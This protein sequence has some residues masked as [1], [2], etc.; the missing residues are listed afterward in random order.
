M[1]STLQILAN[2]FVLFVGFIHPSYQ[3]TE[4]LLSRTSNWDNNGEPRL[5]SDYLKLLGDMG[6]FKVGMEDSQENAISPYRL[7]S[8][9]P[10]SVLK[11]IRLSHPMF[12]GLAQHDSQEFL[13]AFLNDIHEE[14]KFLPFDDYSHSQSNIRAMYCK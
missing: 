7:P 4:L 9:S 14:V 8:V 13:R 6:R 12:R 11:T 3:F 2:W 10:V 1:N 5:T